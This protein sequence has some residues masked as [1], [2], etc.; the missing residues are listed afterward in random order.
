MRDDA[1]PQNATG[2]SDGTDVRPASSL[3]P[4]NVQG[5]EGPALFFFRSAEAYRQALDVL[6]ADS[7]TAEPER[8]HL[9]ESLGVL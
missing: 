2:G 4:L 1:A 3:E 5:S 6:F 8:D 7:S 9:S